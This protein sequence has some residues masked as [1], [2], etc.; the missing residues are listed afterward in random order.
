MMVVIFKASYRTMEIQCWGFRLHPASKRNDRI[1]VHSSWAGCKVGDR[2][3]CDFKKL[4]FVI[5]MNW[6]RSS[7]AV[8]EV[9]NLKR[10]VQLVELFKCRASNPAILHLVAH[11]CGP[12]KTFE[13]RRESIQ[14]IRLFEGRPAQVIRRRVTWTWQ[15]GQHRDFTRHWL[16]SSACRRCPPI[17]RSPQKQTQC[18]FRRVSKRDE[19]F[20]CRSLRLQELPTDSEKRCFKLAQRHS[21]CGKTSNSDSL[22]WANHWHC[23]FR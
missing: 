12:A 22:I 20:S 8:V 21:A 5:Q 1:T 13:M 3:F 10:Y 17:R 2:H 23:P 15:A 9:P 6:Y 16:G 14:G 7:D 19:V 11:L 18:L 4:P